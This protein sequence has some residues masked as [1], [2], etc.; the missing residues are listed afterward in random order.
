MHII[1][2]YDV[3]ASRTEILKRICQR[4]L[5]RVQN[6]VFEGE[7]RKAQFVELKYLLQKEVKDNERVRI[8]QI[9]DKQIY[10]TYTIGNQFEPED[11]IL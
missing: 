6:S 4:F 7:L 10:K 5:H 8:W 9:S 2:A 1:V 11:S 3:E